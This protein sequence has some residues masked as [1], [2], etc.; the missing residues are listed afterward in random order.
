MINFG[1]G[2]EAQGE[3]MVE[4]RTVRPLKFV[5][6]ETLTDLACANELV[7]LVIHQ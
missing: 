4:H 5:G 3:V 7:L 2:D 6:S 1:Q